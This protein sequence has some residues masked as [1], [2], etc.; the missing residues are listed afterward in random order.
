M[1]K[2]KSSKPSKQLKPRNNRKQQQQITLL[3]QALRSLGGAG[4]SVLGGA[5]GAPAAGTAIGTSLGAGLSRWLGSGDY[6]VDSNSIVRAHK[7]STSI[8][9]MHNT[10]Q[11]VVLRHKEFLGTIRGSQLYTVQQSYPINPGLEGSFPWLSHIASNFS[12]YKFRGLVYHYIPT[13]GNAVASSNAALGSVMMQTTYRS[14]DTA[15]A[16]KVEL[17]NEFWAGEVVPSEALVHPIECDPKENPFNVQYVRSGDIPTGD[18][19]LMYDLGTMHI[20]T[21]G[22]QQNLFALG[23]LWVT[24]EVEL[25]KPLLI[26]ST[27]SGS[28]RYSAT[29]FA[30]GA[31]TPATGALLSESVPAS[32][33]G[34]LVATF[35]GGNRVSI[36]K[37]VTG[38]YYVTINIDGTATTGSI[39]L[40]FSP[41][42][43]NCAAIEPLIGRVSPVAAVV[44]SGT[45]SNLRNATYS[46]AFRKTDPGLVATLNFGVAVSAGSAT[47]DRSTINIVR[48]PL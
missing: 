22:Q 20:A 17:L 46:L 36:P 10:G 32:S 42:Y 23:D 30:A 14:T 7:A 45:G 24:Y 6:E 19:R 21:E 33:V 8:P 38:D 39:D 29:W 27:G 4:G 5:F 1:K 3:G 18:S 34:S 48:I 35:L 47:W 15:P 2:G 40:N 41:A 44:L 13:S 12:E 25:K 31:F 9:M 26:G 11:S 37:G 28:N 16:S 43:T